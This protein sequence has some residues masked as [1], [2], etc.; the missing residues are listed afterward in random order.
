LFVI[1]ALCRGFDEILVNRGLDHMGEM[2]LGLELLGQ[3]ESVV[4]SQG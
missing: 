4:K 3:A 2:K 1:P